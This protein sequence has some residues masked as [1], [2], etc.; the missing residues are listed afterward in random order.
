MNGFVGEI[1]VAH[2]TSI[3]A[4]GRVLAAAA[5]IV[6]CLSSFGLCMF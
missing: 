5:D 2:G 4:L 3:E 6:I 1:K